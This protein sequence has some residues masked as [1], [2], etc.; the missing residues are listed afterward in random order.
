MSRDTRL[1]WLIPIPNLLGFA[2]TLISL[3]TG[4]Q[5]ANFPSR[6]RRLKPTAID[7]GAKCR[8]DEKVWDIVD[9][10]AVRAHDVFADPPPIQ[11][12][13]TRSAEAVIVGLGDEPDG[14]IPTE[15]SSEFTSS[16]ASVL[17]AANCSL[18]VTT[19]Q[20]GR[21]VLDRRDREIVNMRR[22]FFPSPMDVAVQGAKLALGTMT[23][24][25]EFWNQQAA[26]STIDPQGRSDACFMPRRSLTTG[27]IRIH[28]LAYDSAGE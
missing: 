6:Q 2:P 21:L 25:W 7:V 17:E 22:V 10:V 28:V 9:P 13:T 15:F 8:R 11:P 1:S 18:A 20:S 12:S 19:Y 27:D 24:V 3:G 5:A 4:R 14:A 23:T 26:A 16:F